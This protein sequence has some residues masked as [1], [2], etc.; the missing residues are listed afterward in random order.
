VRRAKEELHQ[1]F[2]AACDDAQTS[3]APAANDSPRAAA[4][5]QPR[6]QQA[7]AFDQD[8]LGPLPR[9]LRPVSYPPAQA[10]QADTSADAAQ[11]QLAADGGAAGG[12]AAACAAAGVAA[13]PTPRR[14]ADAAKKKKVD[15]IEVELDQ[16]AIDTCA[17]LLLRSPV[18]ASQPRRRLAPGEL[19]NEHRRL[20]AQ[21]RASQ[22]AF[23]NA[24][25]YRRRT[26]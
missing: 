22:G 6:Q 1:S 5:E 12:D 25:T 13:T 24:V 17:T 14:T 19:V 18:T 21:A 11:A 16:G 23:A 8:E 15:W 26:C 7:A 10:E 4:D 2:H 3:L 20:P 9:L